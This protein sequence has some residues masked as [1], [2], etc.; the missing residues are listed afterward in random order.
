M[1]P[2]LFI[3]SS[4]IPITWR[5]GFFLS[6]SCSG[7]RLVCALRPSETGSLRDLGLRSGSSHHRNGGIDGCNLSIPANDGNQVCLTASRRF[8]E[9]LSVKRSNLNLNVVVVFSVRL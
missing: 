5:S 7:A 1:L 6:E 8:G 9:N 4:E 3:R 2:V